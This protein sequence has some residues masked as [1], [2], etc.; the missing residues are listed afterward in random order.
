MLIHFLKTKYIFFDN[1]TSY[2]FLAHIKKCCKHCS[3]GRK[4]LSYSS[5]S[6]VGKNRL[7][8]LCLSLLPFSRFPSAAKS[9]KHRHRHK[10][11]GLYIVNIC[12]SQF[13]FN[14][15]ETAVSMILRAA[16]S[17]RPVI[18]CLWKSC[19]THHPSLRGK[20]RKRKA[21][22]R[23]EREEEGIERKQGSEREK[24]KSKQL[25]QCASLTCPEDPPTASPFPLNERPSVL[26]EKQTIRASSRGNKIIFYM[27]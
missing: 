23:A 15:P 1:S 20:K 26:R 27:I 16:P 7:E 10:A 19:S 22:V 13:R 14:L 24:I 18:F 3:P 17:E 12:W 2:Y 9:A 5:V 21:K 25:Q 8:L 11:K 4:G 6:S